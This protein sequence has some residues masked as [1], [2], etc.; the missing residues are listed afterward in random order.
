M[1]KTAIPNMTRIMTIDPKRNAQNSF[2]LCFPG[3]V[4]EM[5]DVVVDIA[6]K[7]KSHILYFCHK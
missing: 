6:V 2:F 7:N 3:V 5:G 1:A 4:I